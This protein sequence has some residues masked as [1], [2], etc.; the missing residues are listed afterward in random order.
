MIH[1]VFEC[2][3]R[4]FVIKGSGDGHIKKEKGPVYTS[5]LNSPSS[6][7]ST[8]L[9]PLSLQLEKRKVP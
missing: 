6:L 9:G 2:G 7:E 1:I 8:N 3:E 5:C 4:Q